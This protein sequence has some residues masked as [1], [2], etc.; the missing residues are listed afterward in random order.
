MARL[1][2]D[3]RRIAWIAAILLSGVI[4]VWAVA[5]VAVAAVLDGLRRVLNDFNDRDYVQ[6]RRAQQQRETLS[7]VTRGGKRR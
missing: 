7:Q 3:D 5:L 6:L 2:N 4:S 1:N